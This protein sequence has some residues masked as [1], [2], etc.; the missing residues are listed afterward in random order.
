MKACFQTS[1]GAVTGTSPMC[2]HACGMIRNMSKVSIFRKNDIIVV[3]VL[4]LLAAAGLFV[5]HLT[6]Q[7]DG[8]KVRVTIDGELFGEYELLKGV[9]SGSEGDKENDKG[10]TLFYSEKAGDSNESRINP[11]KVSDEQPDAIAGGEGY[12]N[13]GNAAKADDE[14]VEIETLEKE[15]SDSEGKTKNGLLEKED[16]DIEEDVKNGSLENQESRAKENVK[17]ELAD[18]KGNEAERQQEGV[19]RIE[20]PGKVGKCIMVIENG[21]VYMESADCPN[22]ICV[23]HSAISHN[24][25]TIVC[26]PNRVIIEVADSSSDNANGN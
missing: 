11:E 26:L 21:E 14:E 13:L 17:N 23:H 15:N 5:F 1:I 6:H 16:S 19:Q 12:I 24:G 25:E 18:G 9:L 10:N 22:Q 2:K 3:C 4:L 8:K 7:G 20:I